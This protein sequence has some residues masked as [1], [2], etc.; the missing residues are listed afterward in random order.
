MI[1]VSVLVV[2]KNEEKNISKCL[3][4]LTRFDEVWIVDSASRDKT[5]ELASAKNVHVH[6]YQWNGQYPKK[7]QW[8]LDNLPLQHDWVFMV[9]ADEI[10]T[11]ELVSEIETIISQNPDEAGFFIVGRYVMS[12]KILRFG[13]PNQ[14][15]ALLHKSRMEFPIVDD[16][17]IPGMGEIEGHYQPVLK[18]GCAELTI[19]MLKNHMIHDA[20]DDERAWAF[21]H[22]KY[23]RWEI[24]MNQKN[25]WPK[26]PVPQR[27]RAKQFLRRSAF[28]PELVF[29]LGYI[30]KLGFLDG[31]QGLQIAKKRYAYLKKI[32]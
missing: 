9:D 17:D 2:T 29:L 31:R 7:R 26:D 32:V 16:L 23:A 12:N 15:I 21:R 22:E 18:S 13:I 14:K 28:R 27:E 1:A 4:A 20:M 25:A 11:D 6:A 8:C 3:D 5:V 10:V 30:V 19:G 24:G